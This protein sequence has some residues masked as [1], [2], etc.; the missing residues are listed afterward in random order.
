[1]NLT[2]PENTRVP[3]NVSTTNIVGEDG[4]YIGYMFVLKD[5]S[6]LRQ[7]ELK[8]RQREKLAAIG[9]LAAGIAHEVRNP[10]SSIK[11]YVTYSGSLFAQDSENRRSSRNYR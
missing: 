7:L 10:L 8:I 4:Q 2:G 3:V 9:D 1:M 11:G 6:E 5:L